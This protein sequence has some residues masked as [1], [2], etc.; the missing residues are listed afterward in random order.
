MWPVERGPRSVDL[1]LTGTDMPMGVGYPITETIANLEIILK[2]MVSY[3]LIYT[4]AISTIKLSVLLFYL[5]VF[6]GQRFRLITKIVAGVVVVYTLA[7]VLLLVL[8]CRPFAANYDMTVG[9]S[10][11]DQ[12]T[13]YI[14]IGAYNII[15]DVVILCLPIPMVWRLKAKRE[16]KIGLTLIFLVGLM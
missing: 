2:L 5:R 16:M 9:G 11:G 8:I 7:N 4:F 14:S 13:A 12:P 6:V 10:C 3:S 15:S 1:Y